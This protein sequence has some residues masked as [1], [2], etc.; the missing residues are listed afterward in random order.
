M[1]IKWK[2]F[3]GVYLAIIAMMAV[4]TKLLPEYNGRIKLLFT[5]IAIVLPLIAFALNINNESKRD[6]NDAENKLDKC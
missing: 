3:T 5:I 6:M 1:R 2:W 4:A